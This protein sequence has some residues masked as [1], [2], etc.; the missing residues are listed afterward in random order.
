MTLIIAYETAGGG[1]AILNPIPREGEDDEAMIARVI[2]KVVPAGVSSLVLDSSNLPPRSTRDRWRFSNG[3]IV[4]ADPDM[5]ALRAAALSAIDAR[6]NAALQVEPAVDRARRL[7]LDEA[8]EVLA[9]EAD[10]IAIDERDYPMLAVSRNQGEALVETARR[11][12]AAFKAERA[13]IAK[14][15]SDRLTARARVKAATTESEIEAVYASLT[16]GTP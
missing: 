10:R 14:L 3:L 9:R 2:D 5:D 11:V 8:Q 15:E 13:A 16:W 12:F 7:K 4:V 6:F 1:V